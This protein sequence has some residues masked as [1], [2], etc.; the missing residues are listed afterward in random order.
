MSVY[1][2]NYLWIICEPAKN[3]NWE[4]GSVLASDS[5]GCFQ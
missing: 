1:V 4:A 3:Q 5:S 2:F